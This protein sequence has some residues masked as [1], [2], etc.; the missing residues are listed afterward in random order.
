VSI[1][2]TLLYYKKS[3]KS[4]FTLTIDS[5][6]PISSGMGSSAALPVA[7]AGALSLFLGQK[8]DKEKINEIAFACEQKKH[9]FP[10]GGD[11]SASCYG[12]FI[13][14]RKETPDLK[15]I[16][17]IPITLSSQIAKNFITIFTGNPNESTGEMVSML[18]TL[19]QK[20]PA[21]TEKIFNDQEF[22]TR[23]FLSA[24]SSSNEEQIIEIIKS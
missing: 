18:R 1:G 4:G 12:G 10:S 5:Q 16:Q 8:F 7:I 22:L 2:E 20:R 6:I 17:P 13:W 23:N 19:S 9:G 21:Y 3:I 11:N 14:Y 24:L 15:I